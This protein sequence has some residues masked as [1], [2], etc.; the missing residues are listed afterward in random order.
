MTNPLPAPEA[1]VLLAVQPI[2]HADNYRTLGYEL[3]ARL[4]RASDAQPQSPMVCRP[5]CWMDL[6]DAMLVCL[7]AALSDMQRCGPILLSINLSAGTLADA[8]RCG[9]AIDKLDWINRRLSGALMVE[10]SEEADAASLD[11]RWDSFKRAGLQLALDDFGQK[12]ATL[13]R[14]CNFPWDVCKL[15]N[16]GLLHASEVIQQIP[17]TAHVVVEGVETL[18]DMI[19]AHYSQFPLQQGYFFSRPRVLSRGGAEEERTLISIAVGAAG[20]SAP[21]PTSLHTN[22]VITAPSEANID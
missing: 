12:E 15:D 17:P 21:A 9:S 6:D 16:P 14:L 10:V 4:Q 2:I 22:L 8:S 19:L 7:I 18:D 20:H 3:L 11:A 13:N 1:N 5:T